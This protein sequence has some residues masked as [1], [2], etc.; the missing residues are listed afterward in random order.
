V[1]KIPLVMKVWAG[2]EPHDMDYITRSIPS[3]LASNLP[4]GLEVI[5]YDDCSPSPELRKF[6]GEI[7][8][9]DSRVRVIRGEINKGPNLGQQDVFRQIVDEYPDAPYFVNV[10]DD[11]VYHCDWMMQLLAARKD[12]RQFGLNGVFTALNMP[13][14]DAHATLVAQGGKYLLKWKQPALNWLIPR[15]LY[16]AVGP[17][18]DEGIAYDTVYSHWMRLK[19]FPVICLTPSYVQNIGLLGAYASDDTTTSCDFVGEGE[20]HSPFVRLS[21]AARYTLR[22]LPGKARRLVDALS[23]QVAP[24]R[25]GTEFVHEGVTRAGESVAMFSFEDAVRLGWDKNAAAHRVLEVQ[26]ADWGGA[27][28]IR[29]LRRNRQGTPVWVE[30]RWVF[31]PNLREMAALDLDQRVPAPEAVFSALIQQLALLHDMRVVHNKV[32]QDNVYS[33]GSE[34][35]VRLTWLGTE[36]CPG[37]RWAGQAERQTIDMLSGAL[38]RWALP[39]IREAFAAR[40]LESVSPEVMRGE[41]A[42]PHSDLFAAAAVAVLCNLEPLRTLAELEAIRGRWAQGDFTDLAIIR[43]SHVR[44]VMEQ[45]LAVNPETRPASASV[46]VKLLRL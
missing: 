40:Y 11:V 33:E 26:Q 22:R 39:E 2:A 23:H 27:S 18:R 44:A 4:D 13:Y 24:V 7:A 17:F 46:A 31:S 14:R 15:D 6:L 10:D 16:E 8:S 32:R 41:P 3:L 9:R 28:G 34:Q 29:A 19:H 1:K 30:C 35:G 36:P 43:D 5:I 42:T 21:H 20:G 37:V 38:N 45:C 25:W 12:C